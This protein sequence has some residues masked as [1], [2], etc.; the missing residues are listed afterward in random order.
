[1]AST[2]SKDT[3]SP[4]GN[5]AEDD[6]HS[7]VKDEYAILDLHINQFL[8][9]IAQEYSFLPCAIYMPR[10][11]IYIDNK[12][13]YKTR[14]LNHEDDMFDNAIRLR[15]RSPNSI[16]TLKLY[17]CLQLRLSDKPIERIIRPVLTDEA[18]DEVLISWCNIE[19]SLLVPGKRYNM[20]CAFRVNPMF[21][22]YNPGGILYYPIVNGKPFLDN[23]RVCCACRVCAY[24]S[25]YTTS[26]HKKALYRYFDFR[27]D[28]SEVTTPQKAPRR[29]DSKGLIIDKD[30]ANA[31]NNDVGTSGST[32]EDNA[33]E[34]L[35]SVHAPAKTDY[36]KETTDEIPLSNKVATYDLNVKKSF[37][38]KD[39]C[40]CCKLSEVPAVLSDI[41]YSFCANCHDYQVCCEHTV[42][43]YYFTSISLK[44]LSR[45][46]I[47]MK[48]EINAFM[49]SPGTI[50]DDYD[51]EDT[52][53]CSIVTRAY[54]LSVA[55]NTLKKHI[56]LGDVVLSPTP[57]LYLILSILIAGFIFDSKSIAVSCFVVGVFILYLRASSLRQYK[58]DF[59]DVFE[60]SRRLTICGLGLE[61]FLNEV[62]EDDEDVKGV[63]K[64]KE[65]F[66][67]NMK[68]IPTHV[69]TDEVKIYTKL[70]TSLRRKENI[71]IKTLTNCLST[72]VP[73]KL[74][75]RMVQVL[76][77]VNAVIWYANAALALIRRY[78]VIIAAFCGVLGLTSIVYSYLIKTILKLGL[79]L[80]LLA[81]LSEHL[82]FIHIIFV[83]LGY[84]IKYLIIR[85]YRSEWFLNVE[86]FP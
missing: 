10:I 48:K 69:F 65:R 6:V 85:T 34:E 49:A 86:T 15:I 72:S 39:G 67:R 59:G 25:S 11:D 56:G 47:D 18:T 36:S 70:N 58:N 73:P 76:S 83:K 68:C 20:I 82:P 62:V 31:E 78:G 24:L 4:V 79:F 54:E 80:F 27:L 55:A 30:T 71:S 21:L 46:P 74:R 17:E 13:V 37:F 84:L 77:F 66:Q 43:N 8:S 44:L 9:H 38:I 75:K 7:T 3:D 63:L 14:V 26:V 28:T 12:L 53:L 42:E 45:M 41:D 57:Y 52:S 32:A 5:N 33:S 29:L 40:T 23:N 16:I 81:I 50:E 61:N 35:N 64:A 60:K 1:M 2:D 22:T 19:L 51:S